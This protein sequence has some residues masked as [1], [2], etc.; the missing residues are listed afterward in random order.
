MIIKTIGSFI[1]DYQNGT[2]AT[3]I[4]SKFGIDLI[5]WFTAVRFILGNMMYHT[6]INRNTKIFSFI[7][8]KRNCDFQRCNF[9]NINKFIF[10]FNLTGH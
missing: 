10:I 6:D 7:D 5:F 2:G 4:S 1:L 3:I 9:N 8:L